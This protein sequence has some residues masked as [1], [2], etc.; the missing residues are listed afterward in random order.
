MR[1]VGGKL[2]GRSVTAPSGQTTRPTS[3]RARQAIFNILDHAGW[4]DGLEGRR[5][6]DAFAG[7][8]ALGLEALSRGACSCIFIEID[9]VAGS[10]ILQNI[11]AFDLLACTRIHRRSATDP[12]RRNARADEACDLVFLDPP[13]GQGLGEQALAALRDQDWLEPGAIIVMEKGAGETAPSVHG[14]TLLDSRTYG[15][16]RIHFMKLSASE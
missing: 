11:R 2:K 9:G 3:D 14:F 1:L 4:S 13:Y 8:G 16:A 12:G 7:S 6:L 5:V 10:S 15:A